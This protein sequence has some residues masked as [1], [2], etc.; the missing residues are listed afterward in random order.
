MSKIGLAFCVLYLAV[1]AFFVWASSG[2]DVDPKGAF[3]LLQLPITLQLAFID[4]LGVDQSTGGWS[5][6]V[7]YA[8]IVPL[9][10][11]FLYCIGWAI[12]KTL[13]TVARVPSTIRPEE[14][15]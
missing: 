13:G 10:L 15:P 4:W 7:S 3:V 6:G 5:W 14:K 12:G 11:L 2:S 1:T 8:V 9:T